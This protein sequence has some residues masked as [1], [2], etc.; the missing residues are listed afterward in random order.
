MLT[1]TI[2]EPALLKSL[3]D[4]A[5]RHWAGKVTLIPWDLKQPPPA[6]AV[7]DAQL[8]VVG[9]YW[10][11]PSDLRYLSQFR[12]L[13]WVQIPSAGFEHAV[14][15]IPPGVA[16]ANGR[17]VH[18]AETAE[19]AVGLILAMQRGI[20]QARVD[21]LGHIWP[22]TA[23]THSYESL[24]DRKVL[25]VGAGS[26]AKALAVRLAPFEV[27]LKLVGRTSR[28]DDDLTSVANDPIVRRM[29]LLTDPEATNWQ[30]GHRVHAVSELGDL[31]ADADIVVLTVPADASTDKLINAA[32]LARM[33][34]G[35]LL[36]NVA[37]GSV[38]DTDALVAELRSGRLRAAL[39]VTDPEPLPAG[40]P[41]WDCP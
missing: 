25:I 12:Q 40:H 18:S 4:Y 39:D 11:G 21:Q 34:D 32:E 24:A 15:F 35:A 28:V 27:S 14:P 20:A 13:R 19:L 22:T 3:T 6:P 30:I 41:L 26:V 16:L 8:V 2:P 36:V 17:G 33:P 31:L 37:R 5:A 10:N 1:V 7:A 38:V 23:V 9:H 29:D